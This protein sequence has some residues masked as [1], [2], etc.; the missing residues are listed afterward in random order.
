MY[1]ISDTNILKSFSESFYK[2]V[3]KHCKY[4]VVLGYFV[5]ASGRSRATEDIDMI[6]ER[7]PKEKFIA[8]HKYLTKEDFVCVQ[9]DDPEEIFTYLDENM[10]VRYISKERMLPEMEVKFAKDLLD[11]YQLRTRK[12]FPLTGVD[13][14]F[15]SLEMN[16]A[17]KEEYLKSEKDLEDARH[18]RKV[19][20]EQID[21]QKI[22]SLKGL[23]RQWRL[24]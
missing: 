18:L 19:Y 16:I 24:N 8:L 3:E 5:I 13:I 17:F 1:G 14:W 12:K 10:S 21:E 6:I 9:D 15:S 22:T 4:I 11:T 20:K 7:I 23:I 2:I